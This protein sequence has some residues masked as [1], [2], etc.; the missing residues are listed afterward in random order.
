V[1]GTQRWRLSSR[2]GFASPLPVLAQADFEEHEQHGSSEPQGHQDDR[3]QL[4]GQPSDQGGAGCSGENDN[5]S[6][7]KRE[8]P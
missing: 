2:L 5:G 3:E 4:A 1:I 6:R 8:D 7:A